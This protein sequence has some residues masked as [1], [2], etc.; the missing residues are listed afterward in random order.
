M[1]K[2]Y[3]IP[4]KGWVIKKQ[5]LASFFDEILP[6]TGLNQKESRDFTEYWIPRL[7][8]EISTDYIFTTF[9]PESQINEIDSFEI[10][11]LSSPRTSNLE[12]RTSIRV[13]A[14]FKPLEEWEEISPQTLPSPPDR[15]GFTLVEWGGILD[16]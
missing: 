15:K 3:D 12:P 5:N 6:Q 7:E 16:H 13:R 1:V 10:S 4:K 11:S 8:N 14:Y 9:I 2:G